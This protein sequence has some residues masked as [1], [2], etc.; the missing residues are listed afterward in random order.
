MA[1]HEGSTHQVDPIWV[2]PLL[3]VL[4]A[5]LI[6]LL[7]ALPPDAWERPAVGR[8]S[9]KDVVAHLVD[10]DLRRISAARDGW[11]PPPP[12][13]LRGNA[14][15]VG[16]LGRLN[17]E[18]VSAASRLSPAVLVDL[19]SDSG[20]RVAAALSARA[21]GEPALWP[22]AWAGEDASAHWLDVGREYTERWHHQDQIREAVGQPGLTRTDLL[23]PV[24]D[25]SLHAVPHAYRTLRA[26]PGTTLQIDVE[27]DAGGC[28]HVSRVEIGWRLGR[29]PAEA[30]SVRISLSAETCARLLLH[31][32]SPEAAA[33]AV[34]IEGRAPLAEP[35]LR[36]RAVMV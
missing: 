4:H 17:A 30:P 16:W 11:T 35:F 10:G 3:P 19:L 9:V 31:R 14:D 13:S 20:P 24:V 22:V 36:A 28:W 15:L 1:T 12:R 18:W 8:W 26:E 7:R 33:R 29:G 34:R 27:G 23:A 5:A 2:A 25:I 21:P 32:L 6:D